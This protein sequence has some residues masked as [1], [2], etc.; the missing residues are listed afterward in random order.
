M[1]SDLNS[2]QGLTHALGTKFYPVLRLV[3]VP[4]ILGG[5]LALFTI[6]ILKIGKSSK[7]P[8]SIL[9]TTMSRSIG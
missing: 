7:I 1:R 6:F 9:G 3:V 4:S 8:P 5:I 2:P